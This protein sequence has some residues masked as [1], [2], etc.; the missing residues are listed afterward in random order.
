MDDKIIKLFNIIF[1]KIIGK[2]NDLDEVVK[3]AAN[4]LDKSL[5]SILTSALNTA[6][7][8]QDFNL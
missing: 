7:G 4:F 2:I 8:R 1:E 6:E 3:N 5:Q